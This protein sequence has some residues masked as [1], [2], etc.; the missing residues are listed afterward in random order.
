MAAIMGS[1]QTQQ[2]KPPP[3]SGPILS[4]PSDPNQ[5]K[6]AVIE[7]NTAA[8]TDVEAS[9]EKAERVSHEKEDS[10]HEDVKDNSDG[11]ADDEESSEIKSLAED[12]SVK[13]DKDVD[14]ESLDKEILEKEDSGHGSVQS[15]KNSD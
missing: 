12:D 4:D 1:S 3:S 5:A 13:E 9:L 2:K 6:T 11:I 10:G 8:T 14:E 15:R 7:E